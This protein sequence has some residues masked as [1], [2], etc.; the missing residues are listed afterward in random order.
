MLSL[1]H[2]GTAIASAFLASLVEAVEA[3]TI[4]LAVGTVRGWRPALAGTLAGLAFLALLVLA[5]GPLIARMPIHYMQLAV[6][7]L[8]LLFGMRWLR[9][10]ILR[11]A[12]VIALHDEAEAFAEESAALSAAHGPRRGWDAIAVI[13]AFKA[14]VLEG[15]EVVFIVLAVGAAGDLLVPA[16]LGALAACALVVIV[17]CA[18]HRPLARIPENTLKFAVGVLLSA[19]GAFWVGEGLGFHW[20]GDDLAILAIAALF[21]A[22]AA[23]AVGRISQRRTAAAPLARPHGEIVE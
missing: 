20:P 18:V 21:L 14:V 2:A 7:V 10:A 22:A 4:V 5:F 8:L 1:A 11:A 17:G 16:S 6:G 23:A 12:G 9:K 19:F 3:L 15:L 13:T